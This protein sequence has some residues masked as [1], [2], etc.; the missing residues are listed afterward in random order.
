LGVALAVVL[1]ILVFRLSPGWQVFF[2]SAYYLPVVTSGVVLSMIWLYLYEPGFG[3]LNYLLRSAGQEPVLWLS[4][5]NIAP[6]S[7]VVMHHASHWGGA[8]ILLTASLGGIPEHLY[9]AARIDGASQLRQA[10]SITLPLL[11]PA[12][13]YVAI[14]ATISSLQM[15]TEIFVMTGG[16]PNYA[17]ANLV[18]YI[19]DRAFTRFDFGGASAVA[20]ILLAITV[21]VA[22]TQF[23]FFSTD[24][25]Y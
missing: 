7:I 11:K 3:L 4:N 23:R 5:P 2:K 6:Y 19:Y 14:T 9:E 16:G 12:I 18:Y 15:F 20:V 25:E 13:A 21:V 10:L 8:I 1:S 22:V 24:V 17:T